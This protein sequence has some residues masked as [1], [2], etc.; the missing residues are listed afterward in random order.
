M[1]LLILFFAIVLSSPGAVISVSPSSQSVT[2]GNQVTLDVAI[3]GAQDVYAF[4]FDI[5]FDPAILE[6][7]SVSQGTLLAGSG[8]F[9]PGTID[10]GAGTVGFTIDS[11]IGP[12]PGINADGTL[13]QLLLSTLAAGVSPITLSNVILLDS[14]LADIPFTLEDGTVTVTSST[15]AVPEPASWTLLAAGAAAVYLTSRRRSA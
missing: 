1:K 9:V 3:T 2:L 4:Q 5:A 12:I 11:L 14:N 15:A 8:G 13:G 7:L 6:A 10:N